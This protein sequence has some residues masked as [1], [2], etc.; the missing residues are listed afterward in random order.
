M[1][2]HQE[3]QA[4]DLASLREKL[5]RDGADKTWR[6]LHE[7]AETPEFQDFVEREFTRQ[8]APW[9]AAIDRRQFIKLIGA[10]L[11]MAGLS[12]C[13][14]Q[15]AEKI[16]PYVKQPEE[17]IPGLPQFY[18][19]AVSFEGYAMG[20]LVESHT[21]R[22]TKIEGN[23]QHPASLGSTDK[24]MQAEILG[25][26]DP[27]RSQAVTRSGEPSTFAEFV[28][29][30]RRELKRQEI[31]NGRTMR[32]LTERVTSP[33]MADQMRKF[34]ASYPEAK[35]VTYEPVN[36]DNA[37]EAAMNA[38]GRPLDTHYNVLDADVIL[39]FDSDFLTLGPGNVRYARD[40]SDRR[41]V[42]ADKTSMNRVYSIESAPTLT[43]AK[44]DHRIPAKPS[45][46]ESYARAIASAIG[47]SSGAESVAHPE[48]VNAVAQDL[49]RARGR[50]VVVAGRNMPASVHLLAH[51]INAAL[52]NIGKT[53]IYT[54]PVEANPM[55]NMRRLS[56]LAAEMSSGA[57]D[58]L[59]VIGANPVFTSPADIDFASAM[60]NV[61]FT[62][63]LGL[64]ND[65]TSRRCKWHIPMAHELECWGDAR[66]FD[67]T[68]SIMQPLIQPL[69]GGIAPV[70]FAAGLRGI[71]N[72]ESHSI[73]QSYWKTQRAGGNFEDDW[74]H[75][76]H[77][78][79]IP[80]TAFAPVNASPNITLTRSTPAGAGVEITF[81]PDPMIWD[82]R[83]ANNSWLQELPKPMTKATWDN[84]VLLSPKMAEQMGLFKKF[85]PVGRGFEVPLIKVEHEG[86][87]FTAP[88]WVMP[89]HAD[90]S[91]TV[92]LGY[93]RT[94]VGHVGNEKGT[95]AF[96][97]R[98]SSS[99]WIAAGSVSA[100]G[101]M[102]SVASTQHTHSME[103]RHIV[104][105]TT[106]DNFVAN[107]M[108]A[109]EDKHDEDVSMYP[110]R[111]YEGNAW[112]MVIDTNVCTGC[113]ACVAACQAENNIATVGKEQVLRGRDMH[114]IRVDRYYE[115]GLD[116]PKIHH[117]PIPC[118]QCEKAPC[119]VVC[120]V[121]ATSHSAEGLNDMVYNRC[122]GTRYCSNNCPYKVR[123]FNFLQ[124]SDNKT[125][126]I[127]MMHNPNVTV[128]GRGVMEK[129]TYCVQR[130]NDARKH[131]KI[132]GRPIADG[133][134][135]TAC[136][137]ACP[138][139]AI[140]FGNINNPEAVVR[141]T[142]EQ[143]HNYSLLADLNTRPR[144]TYLAKF[145][146]P[147]PAL[148]AGEHEGEH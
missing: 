82:G 119:E 59:I 103:N 147:H 31:L 23:P 48:F 109:H 21:G 72:P 35:W 118:M 15:L 18:A 96:T 40:F 34:L 141:K 46:I 33:T 24:F 28:D 97:I 26:Y 76:L 89:G 99:P 112:G 63:R 71:D 87:S 10:S 100:V 140:V 145:R 101:E 138:T 116:D 126:L 58:I 30:V 143:P 78:G 111:E 86:R 148:G 62:A 22:P 75:W 127:R 139:K 114:W 37:Y 1:P 90:D 108:F 80:N 38:F 11:A 132:A 113:S 144:T 3:K 19:T 13:R 136:Q 67:G 45:E 52:G 2:E 55:N 29:D 107:P 92:L 44:A 125:P 88:G 128:R 142:K 133:E 5:E 104:R 50:S 85:D 47:A 27:D 9:N 64:Y 69:M 39:T 110:E 77:D 65:E 74:R 7:I 121:A 83:Y 53:V 32:I 98:T 4:L 60:A 51:A 93:G 41:R 146:N 8:A 129:C 130:I 124:Y 135:L 57:V 49:Q 43:G 14:P 94:N 73:V 131:A 91:V 68:A 56:E 20:C 115:G 66:A 123:R 17:L 102:Y 81:A 16:V 54:E 117:V 42:R 105:E 36:D 137:A 84:L 12:A 25:L 61:P 120:P 122:V 70:E 79:V 95:N 6:S 106:I 134:V